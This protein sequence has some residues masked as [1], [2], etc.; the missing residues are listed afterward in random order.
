MNVFDLLDHI[1]TIAFAYSGV[2]VGLRKHLDLMGIIIVAFL[3]VTAG[4]ATA[5][6]LLGETPGILSNRTAI[7][8]IFAT[9][10]VS[11][12]LHRSGLGPLDSTPV[13]V[14]MDSIG[15][16]SFAMT[17]AHL[18]LAAGM[19]LFGTTVTAFV[20]AVGGGILRDSLL[21]RVPTVLHTDFYGIIAV[22]CGMAVFGAH[23]TDLAH[24]PVFAAIFIV[25][26]LL[27]LVAWHRSW[28]LPRP[29]QTPD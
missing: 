17:G 22:L 7:I 4:G 29:G 28:S 8:L 9:V 1:G 20:S 18:G 10:G 13:F 12:M 2:L 25:A 19:P 16:V 15:L 6:L 14:V 23:A 21:S 5:Q 26:L 27:R 3:T 11:L 24:G